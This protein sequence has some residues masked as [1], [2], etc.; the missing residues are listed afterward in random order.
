MVDCDVC[1]V[2]I[3]STLS[4]SGMHEASISIS[5]LSSL[6]SIF[7]FRR[8]APG[9]NLDL[10]LK[11]LSNCL[12]HTPSNSRFHAPPAVDVMLARLFCSPKL[13]S[14]PVSTSISK[15]LTAIKI[16]QT[17][18]TPAPALTHAK[19]PA[20]ISTIMEKQGPWIDL[21]ISPSL[22]NNIERLLL[23]GGRE[24]AKYSAARSCYDLRNSITGQVWKEPEKAALGGID[25]DGAGDG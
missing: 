8:Q 1:D 16:A 25:K 3:K 5:L 19:L 23:N 21:H 22:H 10:R 14:S 9:A 12:Q 11:A 24:C 17:K 4:A 13:A 6:F 18:L 20:A 7:P 2:C 15:Q